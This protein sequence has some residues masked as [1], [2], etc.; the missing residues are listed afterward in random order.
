[1]PLTD[2]KIRTSK[3]DAKPFK[4]QDGNGLYL[5]VRPSG[6][7]V[8]RYRYWITPTKD[9]IYTIGDYPEVTLAEARAER[10]RVRLQVKAGKNP[11][12][13]KKLDR[14]RIQKESALTLAAVAEEWKATNWAH[15]SNTYRRQVETHLARD[16]LQDYGDFPIREIT[17]AQLL[18]AIRKVQDRGAPS[19]AKLIRQWAGAI[20]RYAIATLRADSDPTYP[21]R[22]S[23]RM[24]PVQHNAYLAESELP[25]FLSALDAYKG[26]GLTTPAIKLLLLTL[27]RTQELRLA[28]WTE[29]DFDNAIWRIPAE[30]MKMKDPHLVPLS[31][32]AID[33]LRGLQALSGSRRWVFPNMR[34]PDSCMTNTTILRVIENVGYKGRA[35]GHGFRSTAS[36]ILHEQGWRSEIIERQ[37]AHLERNKVKAA[38]NHAG[39]MAERREMLQKWADFIEQVRQ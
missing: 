25:G 12:K 14:V 16:L 20:F 18:A 31:C 37:L 26:Y 13:E 17:S 3:P 23:I 39:Y 10:D 35:T 36:T 7:K 29:I 2:T 27:V 15:W 19:I 22:G 33:I 32:Q 34:N 5:E 11:T 6:A 8:W 1:M 9:G 28:E 4:L 21:L 30:K 24:P 38:Y